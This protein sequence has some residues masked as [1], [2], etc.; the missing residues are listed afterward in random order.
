MSFFSAFFFPFF[1]RMILLS[2]PS[3]VRQYLRRYK[4]H[5]INPW[6]MMFLSRLVVVLLEEESRMSISTDGI[7]SVVVVA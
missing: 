4:Q 3:T 2:S 7:H 6:F 5:V 1:S